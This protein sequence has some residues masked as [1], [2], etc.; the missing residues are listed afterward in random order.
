MLLLFYNIRIKKKFCAFRFFGR[1]C[2][3]IVAHFFPE[4]SLTVGIKKK[5]KVDK[6]QMKKVN[7]H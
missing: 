5:G 7:P 2:I 1:N 4:N 6:W 3:K